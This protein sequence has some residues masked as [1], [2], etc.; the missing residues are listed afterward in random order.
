MSETEAAT[1]YVLHRRALP[2][3]LGDIIRDIP[4]PDELAYQAAALLGEALGVQLSLIHI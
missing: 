3:Q 4:D 2:E 1:P